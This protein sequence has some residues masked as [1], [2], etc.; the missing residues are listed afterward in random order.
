MEVPTRAQQ[1]FNV[2]RLYSH[3][4]SAGEKMALV[5]RMAQPKLDAGP[6]LSEPRHCHCHCHC[7]LRAPQVCLEPLQ[8]SARMHAVFMNTATNQGPAHRANLWPHGLTLVVLRHV[9]GQYAL[10]FT[11]IPSSEPFHSS[12]GALDKYHQDSRVPTANV[13][14]L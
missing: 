6:F 3:S 11:P 5:T 2:Q 9:I 13:S 7:L 12:P 4:E 14:L 8:T 10:S 1:S